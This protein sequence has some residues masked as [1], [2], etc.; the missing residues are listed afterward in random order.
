[1]SGMTMHVGPAADGTTRLERTGPFIPP[2]SLPARNVIVTDSFRNQID[3]SGL[4]DMQ[5]LNV[6][7]HHISEFKWE[8][9]DRSVDIPE[10]PDGGEPEGF[11]LNFPHS[12]HAA[13]QMGPIWEAGLQRGAA[14]AS[15]KI[16]GHRRRKIMVDEST[17]D[18]Q[19][20]FQS[21]TQGWKIVTEPGRQWLETNAG[22]WL[23]FDPC[24]EWAPEN[25]T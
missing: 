1:M 21:K 25:D 10:F 19:N 11:I 15:K 16:A 3:S 22:E 12:E 2:I 23:T 7:K 4:F 9:W 5:Y 17:W 13:E 24:I 18:G 14:T 6:I 8:H 20:F